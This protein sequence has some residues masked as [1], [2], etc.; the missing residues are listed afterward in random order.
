MTLDQKNRFLGFP[1]LRVLGDF[2]PTQDDPHE[3]NLSKGG[4]LGPLVGLV[5]K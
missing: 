4:I 3:R 5:Y 1:G 2:G